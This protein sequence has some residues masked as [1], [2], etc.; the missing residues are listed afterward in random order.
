M[1][2]LMQGEKGNL[3]LGYRVMLC[4]LAALSFPCM[5]AASKPEGPPSLDRLVASV[6]GEAISESD[7]KLRTK[8]LMMHINSDMAVPPIEVLHKQLLEKMILEKLQLQLATPE[9]LKLEETILDAQIAD[10]A[11]QDGLSIDAF[12]AFLTDQ[13]IPIKKF[14]DWLKTEMILAKIQQREVGSLIHVSK[15]DIDAFLASPAGQEHS[16]IEYHLAHI[17]IAMPEPPTAAAIGQARL[18]AESMV[19]ELKNGADFA[20]MA[21]EKSATQQ[22]LQ[23]G[24]LG[25]HK[26][27]SVPTLFT[28]VL[29]SLGAGEIRGPIE[30]SSGFHIIKLLDKRQ[31]TDNPM[32][33]QDKAAEAL[34]R[35][36]FEAQ[37]VR[38]LK[39]LRADSDVEIVH[40]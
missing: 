3:R 27:A 40:P 20:N 29:P 32:Q 14:R 31:G 22:A 4:L 8:L 2:L 11:A 24:D 10:M 19:K 21:M 7:L 1:R 39:Q 34:Y 18:T 25:W 35:R 33:L 12:E 16:D 6:N 15:K 38:W 9:D 5:A 37:L 17:L 13:E 26:A 23:G 28:K 36:Q 30:D